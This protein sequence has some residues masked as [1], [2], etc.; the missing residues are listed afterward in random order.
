LICYELTSFGKPL[1]RREKQTPTPTG[2]EVLVRVAACGVCHSDIH[3][4]DGYFDLGD[5]QTL[6]LSVG[7]RLPLTLGHEIAGE[8]VAFGP[9][10]SDVVAGSCCVVYPWTG[11]G[12][13][14]SCVEGSEHVCRSPRSLG[15]NRDG[16]FADHVLLPHPRYLFNYGPVATEV[17][18]TYPCSGLTALSAL[19]KTVTETNSGNVLILGLGGVGFAAL[20]LVSVMGLTDIAVADVDNVRLG[21]ANERGVC[22]TFNPRESDVVKRIKRATEGGFAFVVD[23][24]GSAESAS[25][26]M[27]VLAPG[28]TLVLVGLFG[29]VLPVSLPWLPLKRQSIQGSYVGSLSEMNDLMVFVRAGV[30][31]PLPV[32]SRPLSEV[33]RALDDLRAGEIVGRL[34]VRPD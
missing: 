19:G 10:V 21:V 17:A 13:C 1:E 22:K 7:T 23:F 28:G 3:L 30:V 15:V 16:G 32:T 25:F 31:P 8:V 34:V 11:C 12:T 6:D 2:T 29:G 9:D 33:Q 4:F 26:A 20:S 27:S 14:L 24:V 18:A 5:D